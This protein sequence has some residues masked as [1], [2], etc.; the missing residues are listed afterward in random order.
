[1]SEWDRPP[2][3][4]KKQRHPWRRVGW[5]IPPRRNPDFAAGMGRVLD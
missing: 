2:A 3:G 5:V 4:C 1:M